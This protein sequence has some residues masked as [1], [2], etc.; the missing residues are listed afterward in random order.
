MIPQ[1]ESW[2]KQVSEIA[3]IRGVLIADEVMTGFGRTETYLP[4][5]IENVNRFSLSRKRLTG[6]YLPEASDLAK[7]L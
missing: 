2:L 5:S 7:K 6:G 4:V 1:H 3:R